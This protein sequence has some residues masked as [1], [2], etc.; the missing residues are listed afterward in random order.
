MELIKI[1]E[2]KYFNVNLYI[3][4]MI[5]KYKIDV[6]INNNINSIYVNNYKDIKEYLEF[7][8]VKKE[9]YDYNEVFDC[10][11]ILLDE[12]KFKNYIDNKYTKQNNLINDINKLID[13]YDMNRNN[14]TKEKIPL[15]DLRLKENINLHKEPNIKYT[16]NKINFKDGPTNKVK[17]NINIRKYKE[18]NEKKD[19][20][21]MEEENIEDITNILNFFFNKYLDNSNNQQIPK[22]NSKENITDENRIPIYFFGPYKINEDGNVDKEN[23][24]NQKQK[25]NQNKPSMKSSF[26]KE[27]LEKILNDALIKTF[28]D[29]MN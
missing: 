23:F 20:D 13:K 6:I 5:N 17:P 7:Y 18:E 9:L 8:K 4:R 12:N 25:Q 16:E 14:E 10:M 1:F 22:T 28:D 19:D 2:C 11:N 21:S 29:D 15:N 26:S 3:N 27:D 24:K